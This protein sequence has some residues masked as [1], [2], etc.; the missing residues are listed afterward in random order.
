MLIPAFPMSA[1]EAVRNV[2]WDVASSRGC[3]YPQHAC[4]EQWHPQEREMFWRPNPGTDLSFH[5]KAGLKTGLQVVRALRGLKRGKLSVNRGL[6]GHHTSRGLFVSL[7]T[8]PYLF[9][10][11]LSCPSFQ[12]LLVL[13]PQQLHVQ[14]CLSPILFPFIGFS[15][16][17]SKCSAG[18]GNPPCFWGLSFQ[19]ACKMLGPPFVSPS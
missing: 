19:F 2:F 9:F 8:P 14:I 3:E 4:S 1:R 5:P 18:F 10:C 11:L 13:P 17:S 12:G 16:F 15:N 7:N 6:P